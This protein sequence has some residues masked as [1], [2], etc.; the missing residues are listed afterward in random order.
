MGKRTEDEIQQKLVELEV[1]MKQEQIKKAV[2][3]DKLVDA[4]K[5]ATKTNSLIPVDAKNAAVSPQQEESALNAELY[6][7]G[8]LAA[9]AVGLLMVLS[10]I[11]VGVGWGFMGG[12]GGL[13]LLPMFIGIGMLIYNYKSKVA[14]AVTVG[15]LG[16]VI[17]TVISRMTL[18]FYGLSLLD[19][20]L[21]GLPV[22]GGI[23]LLAKA[24]DARRQLKEQPKQIK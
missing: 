20:I 12:G 7:F 24:S 2:E 9:L 6:Q 19:L 22:C 18:G 14:Q 11:H 21:L 10:H 15:S 1:A 13:M 16:L 5:Q 4:G 8:G 17:F 3:G 23:A